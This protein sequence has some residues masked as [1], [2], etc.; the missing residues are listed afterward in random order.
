MPRTK[1]KRDNRDGA[2]ERD[3]EHWLRKQFAHPEFRDLSADE[4]AKKEL[5]FRLVEARRAAGLTQEDVAKRLGVSRTQVGRIEKRGYDLSSLRALQRYVQALG[6]GY[7]V[8]V[9]IRRT[10]ARARTR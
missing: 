5:W 3:F 2:P 6:A 9:R 8:E 4:T 7:S 1:P 10:R